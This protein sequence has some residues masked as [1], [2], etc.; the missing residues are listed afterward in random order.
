MHYYRKAIPVME[1][2]FEEPSY[3]VFSDNPAAALAQL[4]LPRQRTVLVDHNRKY[5]DSYADM[6]LMQQCQH[7]IIPRSTFGWWGAWLA[8]NESK[9]VLVPTFTPPGAM[10]WKAEGLIFEG[11]EQL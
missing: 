6:W 11:C 8:A 1:E 2:R 4:D 3:F 5:D 7:F 9:I 10:E